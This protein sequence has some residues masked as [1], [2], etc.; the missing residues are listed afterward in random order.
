M[1]SGVVKFVCKF[2]CYVKCFFVVIFG[3]LENVGVVWSGYV[4]VRVCNVGYLIVC[5][6]NMIV[7]CNEF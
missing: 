1:G 7:C 5:Y 4:I 3:G 2:G 6:D